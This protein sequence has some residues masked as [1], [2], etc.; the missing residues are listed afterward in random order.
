MWD[1]LKDVKGKVTGIR[2]LPAPAPPPQP[3]PKAGS[4]NIIVVLTD[5]QDL[6][7][8]SMVA[9]P[10]T[11]KHI[12]KEGANMTNFFVN[13]PICC[14]S[15]AT[16]LS[17][18]V[19]HNNKA[20]SANASWQSP[21]GEKFMCMHMN[22]SRTLNPGFW[23]ESFVNR[24]YREHGYTTGMF[25]KVLNQMSDYGCNEGSTTP[26]LDRIFTMCGPSYTNQHWIDQF[27]VDYES[28]STGLNHTGER[29]EDYTTSL[30]GNTSLAWIKSV[31]E[32][33]PNHRPFFAWLGPH[34]PHMPAT[35]AE[36]YKDHP[37]GNMPLVKDP[38]YNYEAVGKHSFLP[39]NPA[40]DSTMEADIQLE[41]GNRLRTL[42]SV[43]DAIKDIREYL[44]SVGEW[45]NTVFIFSSDHGY[46]LGQFRIHSHKEEI[47]DHNTRVP[48]LIV[49]PG[50][51]AG[52][53]NTVTSFSDLAPTILELA[54][55]SE[56]DD[57]SGERMDGAS[58]APQ[59]LGEQGAWEKDT[60]L[61]EYQ[62]I[63][64]KNSGDDM[65]CDSGKTVTTYHDGPNNTYSALRIV[66]G[67]RNLL[68]A[69]FANVDDPEAWN[70]APHRINF[71][72]LYDVNND[73]YMLHNIY[74]SAPTKLKDQLHTRL[75]QAIE[76]KGRQACN[77]LLSAD[78]LSE[79][80]DA[81][82][83]V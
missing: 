51:A 66:S 74:D 46:N 8:S 48:M 1:D 63:H 33:G 6:R 25:G 53:R 13:T 47:Y 80:G 19:Y 43:D 78:E 38:D 50:I 27:A 22:T 40:I 44:I 45:D 73:Y 21:G 35:P 52:E 7:L 54:H 29:P 75:H 37:I 71:V 28:P 60:V 65:K 42:L 12:A 30:I 39:D 83:F 55:G 56:L 49:G 23:Q 14:P 70:F 10:Y 18:R 4:P 34:S 5:D 26:G 58:F 76:C 9:M 61:I 81:Q 17:G 79:L 20:T 31:V 2:K 11:M 41:H 3:K 15:R 62:S 32:S 57:E 64:P 72:E 82:L 77:K 36:W 24:L 16:I 59:L 68:Y 69:E 67:S